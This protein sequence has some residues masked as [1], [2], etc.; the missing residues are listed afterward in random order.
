MEGSLMRPKKFSTK[1]FWALRICGIGAAC[2]GSQHIQAGEIREFYKGARAQAMGNAFIG[3]ADDE[4]ALFINPAGLA[5]ITRPSLNY[6]V[7]DLSVASDFLA[8]Y[9]QGAEA[10]KKIDGD[11]LNVIMGKN[12][13]AEAQIT[14]TLVMPH[15]GVGVLV[16]GQVG[17]HAENQALPRIKLG[18]QTT[19]GLQVGY[20]TAIGKKASK[21]FGEL[22]V[23]VAGKMVW[24]RG[25]IRKVPT[26]TLLTIN[27]D[28]LGGIIGNYGAGYGLDLGTQ[29]VIKPANRF[30]FSTGFVYTDIGDT[31][32]GEGPDPIKGNLGLGFAGQYD[33]GAIKVAATYD[34]KHM[35]DRTDFRK[36]NHF[37]L[38]VD[39]PLVSAYAG[40]NQVYFTYGGSVDVWLLRVTALSY[41]EEQGSFVF[42]NPER[43]W[44]LRLA[45]KFN[46]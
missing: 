9:K 14:P 15:I 6:V 46:I 32:F 12:L 27:K 21:R 19:S 18:Y 25:G 11:S 5:G 23:G 42:Q 44:V 30:T 13:T 39:L 34:Y 43:R 20:G 37:G 36:K 3:L 35:L 16:D 4:E 45:L 8:T 10:F 26:L 41:A 31:S 17:L 7:A 22:R 29:Y 28:V 40:F 1:I 24:R 2:L 38:E 33:L